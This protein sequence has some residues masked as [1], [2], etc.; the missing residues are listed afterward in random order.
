MR[1]FLS[2]KNDGSLEIFLYYQVI[3]KIEVSSLEKLLGLDRN[4]F[5]RGNLDY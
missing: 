5:Q 2:D 4:G 1:V 3:T